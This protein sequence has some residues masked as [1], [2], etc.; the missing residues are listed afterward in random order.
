VNIIL[1]SIFSQPELTGVGKYNGEMLEY[2]SLTQDNIFA[3]VPPPYYPEWKVHDGY[4]KYKYNKEK[5]GNLTVIRCPIY[6]PKQ[7]SV[8][9][10]IIYLLSFSFSSAWPLFSLF[11]KKID[12]IV[13]TQPTLFCVP[14]TLVFAKLAKCKSVLHIQD[15]EVDAMLGLNMMKDNWVVKIIKKFESFLMRRFDLVTSI[16]YSMLDRAIAKGVSEKRVTLFPNWSD[17][18]FVTPTTCGMELKA[19]WGFCQTDKII[20]YAGNIG[21]KQG[22]EVVLETA[23]YYKKITQVKFVL[24]GTGV[25]LDT[26]KNMAEQ[27]NITNLFFKPLQPWD[28]VPEM[29]ALTAIHLVVQ[30][31]GAADAVLPSKLTN[32]LSAGGHALVTA[33]AHTELGQIAQKHPGIYTYVEPECTQAFII[34]I[35]NLL[36]QDLTN[37]NKVAREYAE[38]YLAKNKILN[39]FVVDLE[40]LVDKE[41]IGSELH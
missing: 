14:L 35:G 15:F 37:H 28:R 4:E 27:Q 34:A 32:I 2:L 13:V 41:D 17:T 7:M 40:H 1:Y 18:E 22:L 29:L 25:Y 23:K 39:Q 5:Q 16:S 6:V 26:L 21:Q 36:A 9:K 8:F 19:E 11:R 3:V 10:R 33:E 20:L 30:K 31:K 24:V 12:V 38:K